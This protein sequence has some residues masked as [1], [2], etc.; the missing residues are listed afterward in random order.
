MIRTCGWSSAGL[1]EGAYLP[2]DDLEV[3]VVLIRTG[4]GAPV[5]EGTP[6]LKVVHEESEA[7]TTTGTGAASL[8]DEIVR[9]GARQMLAA[10]FRPRWPPTSR[11]TLARS[12]STVTGG[13]CATATTSRGRWRRRPGRLSLPRLSGDGVP[14][15]ARRCVVGFHA[16]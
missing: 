7:N 5:Q 2:E 8:L 14:L 13:W 9:D 15:V 1:R 11:R 10:P 16:T 3:Q 4:V 12:M 6:M